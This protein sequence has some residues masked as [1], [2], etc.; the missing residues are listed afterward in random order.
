MKTHSLATVVCSM[1]DAVHH[2]ATSHKSRN[3][4]APAIVPRLG[5]SETRHNQTCPWMSTHAGLAHAVKFERMRGGA[6]GKRCKRRA[7]LEPGS[8][9][10]RVADRTI[11]RRQIN[12]HA[13]PR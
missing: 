9:H 6:V 8:E 13:A 11:F 5:D 7:Q 10:R 1:A 3:Q 12:H 4:L 2:L